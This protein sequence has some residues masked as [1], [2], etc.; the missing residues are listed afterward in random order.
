ML[1]QAA[2]GSRVRIS[3]H[4]AA[5][6]KAHR[7]FMP[8]Q[9]TKWKSGYQPLQETKNTEGYSCGGKIDCL[10]DKTKHPQR[11]DIAHCPLDIIFY[12]KSL[13]LRNGGYLAQ[14]LFPSSNLK[15]TFLHL[16]ISDVG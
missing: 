8:T 1:L 11:N 5:T 16:K 3:A 13:P 12:N 7:A 9:L 14:P 10:I 2:R 15:N 6:I 4:Y